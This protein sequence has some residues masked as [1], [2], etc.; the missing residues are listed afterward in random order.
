MCQVTQNPERDRTETND[1]N[2]IFGGCFCMIENGLR[3]TRFAV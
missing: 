2:P 3:V 1:F